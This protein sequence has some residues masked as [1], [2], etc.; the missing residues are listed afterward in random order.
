MCG[1]FTLSSPADVVR[2]RFRIDLS[3]TPLEPRY[4]ICPSEDLLT[5]AIGR[6]GDR[7]A[8]RMRW[9]FVPFWEPEPRT[10]LST[11][12]ARLE[13]A[14]TSRIYR[15]AFR[16]RRCLIVADGFY[17]WQ[18]APAEAREKVP[19]WLHR[20]D[21]QPFAFAGL[22]SAW[23]PKH[24]PDAPPLLSCTILTGPAGPVVEPIHARTP[25]I[26][27]PEHEDA[28]IDPAL[29][30]PRALAALLDPQAEE[31]VARRV[32]TAV[33]SPRSDGPEL[34]RDGEPQL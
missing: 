27:R 17:E 23:R 13:S 12:N 22:Y 2:R 8:V 1:R 7:R 30:D 31:L 11:I 33:N 29:Q 24:E 10:R 9:G 20:P 5:V 25:I 3:G 14:P 28:W 15:D 21:G 19:Y 26:L 4:N 32:S 6:A 18:A 34:I 16:R